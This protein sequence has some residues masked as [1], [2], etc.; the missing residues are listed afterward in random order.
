MS[1]SHS[2]SPAPDRDDDTFLLGST[3]RADDDAVSETW[4]DSDGD[5]SAIDDARV[6]VHARRP[7]GLQA[8]RP[9]RGF[10]LVELLVVIA[11]VGTLIGLLL[12]AVQS[13]REAA[14]R[15]AC[16]SNLRQLPLAFQNY[17]TAKKMLP[18]LMRRYGSDALTPAAAGCETGMA[19]RSWAAD[20]LPYLEETAVMSGYDL[21]KN[22]WVNADNT[23]PPGGTAN[24]LDTPVTGNRSLV[25]TQFPVMQC[26][27]SPVPNR[28]QDKIESS[29]SKPRKTGACGD[30]FLVAGTGTNFKNLSSLTDWPAAALPGPTEQWSGCVNSPVNSAVNR[31]RSTFAKITDGLSKTILLAECAGREDVWRAGQRTAANA[32]N[33]SGNTAC[34]RAQGGAWAT[35]DNPH[36]FGEKKDAWCPAGTST[37]SGPIPP[38]LFRVNGSNE[39]GWLIYAFHAGGANVAMVDGS[40]RFVGEDTSV[41]ILGQLATRAGGE[42]VT[43]D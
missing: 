42:S 5:G 21:S 38:E 20:V 25:R 17:E 15:T 16:S 6:A 2:S 29:A 30:Y 37:L 32:D 27:S 41:Q 35:N 28:I 3:R 19:F 22:W 43:L 18:P 31:P 13:A 36:G 1:S 7:D 34:A 33:S 8:S 39:S 10:T 4:I 11:I 14:R 9:P 24:V 26:P 23:V 40:V 12:P